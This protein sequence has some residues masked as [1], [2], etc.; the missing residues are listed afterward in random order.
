M[1]KYSAIAVSRGIAIGKSLCVDNK[2]KITNYRISESEVDKEIERLEAMIAATVEEL[3][4]FGSEFKGSSKQSEIITI[5]KTILKDEEMIENIK[6]ILRQEFVT[7]EKALELNLESIKTVFSEIKD[8]YFAARVLDYQDVTN[9][10]QKKL[11][12][13]EAD[14]ES[15]KD[16]VLVAEEITPSQVL[17]AF[18]Q[19][20]AG[21]V[22]IHGSRKSHSAILARSLLLPFVI[23]LPVSDHEICSFEIIVDGFSG[24]VIVSPTA[25]I[26]EKYQQALAEFQADKQE[27][28]LLAGTDSATK[29][30]KRVPLYCNIE[31]P[32]E[33]TALD[34]LD[35]DGI[36]LFRTEFLF[37]DR[38]EL[39]DEEE[40]YAIYSKLAEKLFPKPVVIR[41]IDLGGDKIAAS[42]IE[43]EMNPN[44]GLR[45]IRLSLKYLDLFKDQ[46]KAL[47]RA[48]VHGNIK[49]MFPMVSNVAEI[50]KAK[51][52]IRECEQELKAEGK[53]FKSNVAVGTMIEI[54]SAAL[55]AK[56]ISAQCDFLS[57]GTNDLVQYTL[58]VDRNN[59]LVADYYND[60]DPAVLYL[61]S[62]VC[63]SAHEVG[64]PVAVCGEMASQEKYTSLL[65]GLGVDELSTSP[66]N[67]GEIKKTILQLDMKECEKYAVSLLK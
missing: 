45:G 20:T 28:A 64:I 7:V 66:A 41:T 27:L 4:K 23:G 10:L 34:K 21:L 32:E 19:Q 8:E 46:L 57:I 50:L 6:K 33:I 35:I 2:F 13:N 1:Q 17:E 25:S 31:I 11:N 24:D 54:P 44:L 26:K 16:R 55:R 49:I 42:L 12:K 39:P 30:G 47:L 9:R 38:L 60:I 40:Q 15:W 63:S 67:Y 3:D 48:A 62:K 53:K 22:S 65:L 18:K 59:D 37:L 52:I 36:G 5:H 29:D 61:I 56:E 43:K 58:A 51:E 14:Q